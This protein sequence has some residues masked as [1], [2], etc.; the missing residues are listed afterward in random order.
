MLSDTE[1]LVKAGSIVTRDLQFYHRLAKCLGPHSAER[2]SDRTEDQ[3]G[4]YK[5]LVGREKNM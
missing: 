1:I 3:A 2:D 5:D 4:L